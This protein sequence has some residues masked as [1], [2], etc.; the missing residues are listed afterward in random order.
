MAEISEQLKAIDTRNQV[1]LERLKQGEHEKFAPFLKK[2]ERQVRIRLSDEGVTVN[3]KKRLNILLADVS[4]IQKAI[5]DDYLKQLS[6]DLGEIGLSQA[7]FEAK[8]YERVVAK[9]ESTVP[10]VEQVSVAL[11]VNPLQIEGY[12]GNP[13]LEPFLKDWSAKETQRVKTVIQQGFYQGQTISQMTAN[14]RGTKTN[15]YNDGEWAKVNRSNRTIVRTAVQ[16]ASTQARHETMNQNTDLIK[17][18]EWVSTLDSRTSAQ[19]SALDGMRFGLGEGPLPPLHPNC[20]SS[21]TVVLDEKYDFLD[22]GATRASKGASGGKQVDAKETYYSWLKGQSK[23]FQEEAIG[24]AKSKLLR[25]GGL[26]AEQFA[27]QS[28]NRNFDA[29]T[30]KEWKNKNPVLFENAGI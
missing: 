5:Y 30:L 25:D 24:V 26:T 27:K 6:L 12:T 1:L 28:L 20:R 16:H 2:M 21:T 7:E 4:S 15:N 17:G 3:N 9:F 22:K 18:Y 23:A 14:L 19:C 13:L 10:D 29:L 8:S 11:R